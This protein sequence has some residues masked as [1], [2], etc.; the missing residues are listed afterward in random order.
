MSSNKEFVCIIPDKPDSLQ[1]RL[2]VR[3]QHLENVKP[4]VNNGTI[5]VG[6]GMLD[7][8]PA[9]GETPPFKGSAMIVVAEEE[10]Q[11][12]ELI[13]NDIYATS[14][15]WD[16]EGMQIIPFLCAVR[17]GDKPLP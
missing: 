7:S 6:G 17:V 16:V 11:V 14:G 4:L 10:A 15:V 5:V 13:R 2:E 12:R 8:H 9:P 1:K 3:N